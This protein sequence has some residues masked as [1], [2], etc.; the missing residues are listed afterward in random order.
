MVN[1]KGWIDFEKITP[2]PGP[3]DDFDGVYMDAEEAAEIVCGIPVNSHPLIAEL[4]NHN[5]A[6]FDIKKLDETS[7]KQFVGFLENYRACGYLHSKD[8]NRK[9]WGRKWNAYESTFDSEAG[10]A[11]FDTAWSCPGP[12]L[13]EL[14]KNFPSDEIV[15]AYADEDIGSNCGTFTLKAGEIT[16]S[17]IAPSWSKQSDE[18]K[19]KWKAFACE[20]KGLDLKEYDEE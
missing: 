6:N 5:R 10:T 3:R 15:V 1:D 18:D 12:V 14:S 17:D 20:V 19:A 9:K 11:S 16:R 4:K 7:F 8:F 2:F 13:T